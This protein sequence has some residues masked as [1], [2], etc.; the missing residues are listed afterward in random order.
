MGER[1]GVARSAGCLTSALVR[2][3]VLV[4]I[5]GFGGAKVRLA[6][7]LDHAGRVQ[8][9]RQMAA[10]VLSAASPLPVAVAC[11]DEDVAAFAL[12]HGA[13]VLWTP[14]LGLNGAVTEAVERLAADGYDEVVVAHADLPMAAGIAAVAGAEDT[15]TLVPDR[16]D[17][18]TN[19]LAIPSTSGFVFAYGP[20]SFARHR[21][22]AERLGLL[23]RV[24][25]DAR[26]GWD[27]DTPADLDVPADLGPPA[28]GPLPC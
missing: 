12:E 2:S 7:A 23:V 17:D 26:L 5:K 20:G 3:A 16:H 4:P 19:V 18:G 28:L 22:E 1:S 11:D 25:R 8:L 24:V 15:V 10:Q 27:V 14:G 6:G 21:A 9:A 13:V